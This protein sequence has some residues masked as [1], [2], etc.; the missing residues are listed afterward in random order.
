[1]NERDAV[2]SFRDI[3]PPREFDRWLQEQIA[4]FERHIVARGGFRDLEQEA[5]ERERKKLPPWSDQE[6]ARL[7]QQQV[8]VRRLGATRDSF[9]ALKLWN[10]ENCR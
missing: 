7:E 9:I 10:Y 8:E 6:R 5:R 3:L 2:Q 4:C 1:M